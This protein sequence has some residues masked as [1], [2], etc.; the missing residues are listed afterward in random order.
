MRA[1]EI[2]RTPKTPNTEAQ[3]V[4]TPSFELTARSTNC[5]RL[6]CSGFLTTKSISAH[7]QTQELAVRGITN[8][9]TNTFSQ[10]F[11]ERSP[12]M[13][14]SKV[15]INETVIE[16]LCPKFASSTTVRTMTGLV[17]K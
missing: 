9:L 13:T 1:S 8:V 5:D 15:I 16:K 2:T 7:T 3:T 4:S 6:Q 12:I 17:I 10:V 14:R 11:A